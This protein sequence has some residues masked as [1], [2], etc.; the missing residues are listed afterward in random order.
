MNIILAS[1]SPRRQELLGLI[2]NDFTVVTAD[3][4]ERAIEEQLAGTAPKK[5]A[6]ELA[7]A[8]AI[9]VFENLGRP[10][11]T[12]VIGADT[13]VIDGDQIMGKPVDKE[14]ALRMLTS[15]SGHKH[16]VITGVCL[17]SSK[18]VHAFAEEAFVEFNSLDEYQQ[19]LIKR[20]CD[21]TEPYDKAGAY[22]IQGG[23]ALLVKGIEG[24]FFNV[25][26]LPVSRLAREMDAVN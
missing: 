12:I 6:E 15:L 11:D 2:T 9:A 23:G 25:V 4:D 18:G 3:V 14:D 22:G 21:S 20:Y 13:S 8:K 10:E 1:K 19:A 24:D 5:L 26:G 17:V 16:S 7:K